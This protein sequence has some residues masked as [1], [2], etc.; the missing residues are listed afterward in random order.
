MSG[1]REDSILGMQFLLDHNRHMDFAKPILRIDRT[2]L[3]A[4]NEQYPGL[5]RN[6]Y[7]PCTKMAIYSRVN[8]INFSPLGI[9]RGRPGGVYL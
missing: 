2:T 5:A 1:I 4:A 8:A 9:I 7:S 3:K 6:Y